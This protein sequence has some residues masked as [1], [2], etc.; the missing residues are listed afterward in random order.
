MFASTETADDPLKE[1]AAGHRRSDDT[2]VDEAIGRAIEEHLS[3][4]YALLSD[5]EK[6][7]L[8][9]NLKNVEYALG[10]NI[11]DLSM[12]FW[13]IDESHAFEGAHVI[14]K[15]G[16]ST[17]VDYLALKLRDYGDRFTCKQEFP[18][19]KIEYARKTTVATFAGGRDRQ[20][21]YVDLSD[22]CRLSSVS[23]EAVCADFTVCAL[24]LG[25]LKE[26]VANEDNSLKKSSIA[27]EPRLPFSKRDAIA[28]VGFGLLDKVY[29]QFDTAFWRV[30]GVL[31]SDQTIFGNAT[32]VNPHQYMF[33]DI[34]KA[35]DSS[36]DSP[37]ILM[38]LIS[39]K[40]A[41][42]CEM[43]SD[44]GIRDETM[45]TLRTLFDGMTIPDPTVFKATRWGQDPFARGS[46]TFLPPGTTDQDFHILRSPLNGNGD[47]LLLD[48]TETMRLF[49]AGEHTTSLHPSM[50]HGAMLSGI[51]A[52][53]EVVAAMSLSPQ[54]D[55]GCDRVLPIP[56]FR[57]Q[58]PT[59]PLV[60]CLCNIEGSTVREGTLLAFTRGARQILVH[61]NCAENSPEVEVDDGQWKDVIKACN[62]SKNIECVMCR[63]KGAS[64]GCLQDY[65]GRC[66][67]VSCAE[68]TG[69]RFDEDGKEYYCDLHRTDERDEPN[70]VSID[71]Y[72][73]RTQPDEPLQCSLCGRVDDDK[74]CGSILAF[75]QKGELC[76]VHENCA[77]KTN[78]ADTSENTASRMDNDFQNIFLAI[79]RSRLCSHC[80]QP[81]AST[82]CSWA[83]CDQIYHY[84]CAVESGFKFSE[85]GDS[86]RCTSHRGETAVATKQEPDEA[87]VADSMDTTG[88]DFFQH[89]LFSLTEES[90]EQEA[91]V[92]DSGP[93]MQDTDIAP[94][95][96]TKSMPL[97]VPS[98]EL[99]S[100]DD[101]DEDSP[102]PISL[103]R[104]SLSTDTSGRGQSLLVRSFRASATSRWSMEFYVAL[105]PASDRYLL[106]V[107][108]VKPSMDGLMIGDIINSFNGVPIG[109]PDLDTMSKVLNSL[110][111]EVDILMEI[112]RPDP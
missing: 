27:F 22:T 19:A 56:L 36:V 57:H 17:I 110:S 42:A 32:G 61:N 111:Q 33:F 20:A 3:A 103:D 46:Y 4:E 24:P 48:R 86:F 59:T 84:P 106:T 40:E 102:T 39:G 104:I 6:K 91:S 60:C 90:N 15:Q 62:R 5:T 83:S 14:L 100:S 85:K 74:V 68:D 8:F 35:L 7:M 29:M 88:M 1:A 112:Q 71:F 23:G 18:I 28:S 108:D 52:A 26:A 93:A 51:R 87:A 9:W 98:D 16:Y 21:Q 109:S 30:P 55:T 69:W 43:K 79:E 64:V 47:S 50:A 12:K 2:S 10:A 13:D 67:H 70:R 63:H 54:E 94:G 65:C 82:S 81:G 72:K 89:A 37:A 78:V 66:F 107:A 76:V 95:S 73:M 45:T 11:A 58:N 38:C 80:Q 25:V 53:K 41:V 77:Q 101:A 92:L 96:P 105:D 97:R 31:E 99:P 34:G 75:R 44:E 49:F